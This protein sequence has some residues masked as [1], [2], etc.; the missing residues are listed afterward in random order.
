MTRLRRFLRLLWYYMVIRW[1]VLVHKKRVFLLGTPWYGNI[2]DQAICLGQYVILQTVYKERKIIDVPYEIFYSCFVRE[3][4]LGIT[5][6]DTIFMQGGG[7]MGSLYPHEEQIRRD[8]AVKY[9]RN[10][11]IVMPVSIF[12]A[13]DAEGKQELAKSIQAYEQAHD[14]TIIQRDEASHQYALEHFPMVRN[15]LAPD[16]A[17][18]LEGWC[19]AEKRQGVQF[20]LRSD[21]EK[22]SS[23]ALL[24]GIQTLLQEKNIPY[25]V[26]DTTINAGIPTEKRQARVYERLQMAANASVVVTDRFHGLIFSVVTHT[27]VIVFKSFDSKISSGIKWFSDLSWVHYAEGW[28][29]NDIMPVIESYAVGYKRAEGRS[30]CK[31]KIIEVVRGLI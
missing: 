5:K 12:F 30:T 7:N 31:E 6:A 16:A 11:I 9:A 4:G 17:T 20:F 1:Q 10:K 18:A 26:N 22:V 14:L 8:I 25:E 21:K 3:F 2:G 15:V 29:I 24:L 13:D 28:D 23:D 19:R 27:P